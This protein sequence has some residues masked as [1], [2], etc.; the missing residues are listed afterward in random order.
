MIVEIISR[1]IST[2]VWDRSGFKLAIPGSAVGLDT[3][4]ATGPGL[5]QFDHS[6]AYQI[7]IVYIDALRPS[8]QLFSLLGRFPFFPGLIQY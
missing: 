2:N 4:C 6:K 7:K 8:Q 3:A 1:S 5:S